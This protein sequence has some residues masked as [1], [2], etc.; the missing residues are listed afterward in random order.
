M[1]PKHALGSG[2]N[3]GAIQRSTSAITPLAITVTN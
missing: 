3:S 1:A 2:S